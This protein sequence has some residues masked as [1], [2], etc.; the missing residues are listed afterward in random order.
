MSHRHEVALEE[1]AM[2][3]ATPSFASPPR[4]F[5]P[6]ATGPLPFDYAAILPLRGEPGNIVQGVITITPESPFMALG[7]SYGLEERRERPLTGLGLSSYLGL[8][9]GGVTLR[10]IPAR[11]LIEGVRFQTRQRNTLLA[12]PNP[13]APVPQAQ[14]D[15]STAL[16]SPAFI[17]DNAFA[18]LRPP[19]ADFSF[20][21]SAVDTSSGRE[22]QDQ[23][24]LSTASLGEP[25]GRRPFR[26]FAQPFRLEGRSTIRLQA[27]EQT[28][29]VQGD[30]CVVLFGYKLGGG[31]NCPPP[32]WTPASPLDF[33][34]GRSMPF[35]YSVRFT[36][37]GEAGTRQQQ[38]VP[39]DA[40]EGFRVNS[41][42][43][44]LQ[45]D[46]RA[47]QLDRAATGTN[48]R[49]DLS[50]LRVDH[51]PVEAWLDG[52]RIRPQ[53]LRF[54]LDSSGQLGGSVEPDLADRIFE[55][56]NR[57]G[58]VSF[59]YEITDGGTGRD[60]QN[61][62]I[63]NIGGLGSADGKRPFK[64]LPRPLELFPRSTLKLTVYETFGRGEL[65]IVFQGYR[66]QGGP[67]GGPR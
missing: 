21:L 9:I 48:S 2:R 22:L 35:D 45:S 32:G 62:P 5:A 58:D 50:Q 61:I 16:L 20:M 14:A 7:L 57:P 59:R 24:M 64:T 1:F 40:G 39:V 66:L 17:N 27:I 15:Y 67:K 33:V 8:T 37:T 46:G 29:D 38:E 26:F 41:I 60:L 51:L 18:S 65:F 36:L 6:A 49:V 56:L 4:A 3:L 12:Q 25:N 43:Y 44:G 13:L 55:R 34:P 19:A 53:Y 54:A 28:P 47:V 23:P 10:S 30:L 42:A 52:F 31:S 63:H 11:Y